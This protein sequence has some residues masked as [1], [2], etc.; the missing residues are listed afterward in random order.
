MGFPID[1][2]HLDVTFRTLAATEERPARRAVDV[3][4]HKWMDDT[5]RGRE[6]AAL[7]GL[8]GRLFRGIEH[9]YDENEEANSRGH[10]CE[11]YV[12][13]NLRNLEVLLDRIAEMNKATGTLALSEE[14]ML[15]N[16]AKLEKEGLFSPEEITRY[17]TVLFA[18]EAL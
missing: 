5:H 12:A 7:R 6:E 10:F 18:R 17:K 15:G 9:G 14:S 16:I 13:I 1:K 2:L 4:V 3:W 8:T 11:Y